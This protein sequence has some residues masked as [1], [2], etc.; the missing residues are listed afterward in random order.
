ME[1]NSSA[2]KL[3]HLFDDEESDVLAVLA[4]YTTVI[5]SSPPTWGTSTGRSANIDREAEEGHRRLVQ[6]NFAE[7]SIYNAQTFRRRFRMRRPLYLHVVGAVERHDRYFQQG[8]DATG[9]LGL[10]ALHKCTAAIRQLAYGMLADAVD[11]YVRI[12]E[13]TAIKSLKRFCAARSARNISARRLL[14]MWSGFR[15]CM[16]NAALL[17]C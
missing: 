8:R 17:V 12:A 15:T 4:A 16:P 2:L 13:T 14:L 11:E 5:Q 7:N 6:D 3:F 10:S 1:T 9:K